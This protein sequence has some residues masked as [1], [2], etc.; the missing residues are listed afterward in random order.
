MVT[1]ILLFSGA[2]VYTKLAYN[3]VRQYMQGASL[4][5][6]IEAYLTPD[7]SSVFLINV[8]AIQAVSADDNIDELLSWGNGVSITFQNNVAITG[9]G[10]PLT[11]GANKSLTVDIY[12]TATAR[13]VKFYAY[14][15]NNELIALKG[16]NISTGILAVS[17]SGTDSETWQFDVTALRKVYMRV[18][19]ISGGNLNVIG[20]VVL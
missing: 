3:E 2:K 4:A 20:K 18:D 13:T 10:T 8:D 15:A 11:V 9:D 19:I 17:T 5:G 16:Y 1:T 12:G 7:F 14:N 6:T